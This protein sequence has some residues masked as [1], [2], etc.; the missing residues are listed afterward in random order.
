MECKTTRTA[1]ISLIIGFFAYFLIYVLLFEESLSFWIELGFALI[2][3]VVCASAIHAQKQT[4]RFFL[5]LPIYVVGI[6]YLIAQLIVSML[7]MIWPA[8]CNPWGYVIGI[9]LLGGFLC[10]F[11]TSQASVKHITSVDSQISED[12][13]FIKDLIMQLESLKEELPDNQQRIDELIELAQFSNL[14]SCERA[15]AVEQNIQIQTDKLLA[16]AKAGKTEA[17]DNRCNELK[18]LLQ[19]RDQ[20]CTRK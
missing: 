2:A 8:I 16:D 13:S 19:Q 12:T 17:L 10:V 7:F 20:I 11:L 1:M 5:R 6:A 18:K 4:P 9:L 15:H 14:R 3:F